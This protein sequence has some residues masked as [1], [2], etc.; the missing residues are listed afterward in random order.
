MGLLRFLAERRSELLLLTGQH[1]LLVLVS[2]G[3]AVAIGVPL[4]I[5]LAGRPRLA[6]PVLVL[7]NL[8]VGDAGVQALLPGLA[9]LR[10]LNLSYTDV[11]D[12]GLKA[13]GGH[14]RGG[15]TGAGGR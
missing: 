12:E 7:A 2:A 10:S 8:K 1:V 5:A 4:G 3:L 15:P 14:P 9:E 11:T 13:V 6:R